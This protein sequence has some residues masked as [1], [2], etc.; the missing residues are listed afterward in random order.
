MQETYQD[1]EKIQDPIV[2]GVR[3]KLLQRSQV[4][5]KKY[6]TTLEE[7]NHDDYFNHLQQE[8]MD[9]ANYIEKLL[10]NGTTTHALIKQYPNDAEL[11]AKIREI[12]NA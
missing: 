6:N 4:G 10:Q 12:F 2:E 9:G 3:R 1:L 5:V 11:G 8:L 7:N